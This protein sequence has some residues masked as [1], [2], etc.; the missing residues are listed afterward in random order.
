MYVGTNIY[1]IMLYNTYI[2]LKKN[3]FQNFGLEINNTLNY[4]IP[5]LYSSNFC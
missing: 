3:T 1:N 5:L 2:L 4:K